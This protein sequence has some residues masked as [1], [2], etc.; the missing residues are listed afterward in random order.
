ML[1]QHIWI[2][3][4]A[5]FVLHAQGTTPREKPA[6]YHVQARLPGFDLAAEYLSHSMPEKGGV[7]DV[8]EYLVI[9]V[10]V[11]PATKEVAQIS[12]G[13]FMLQVTDTRRHKSVLLSQTPGMVAASLK[14]PNWELRPTLEASAGLGDGNVI[15]GRP[16]Q[17][18]RFPG[19]PRPRQ[20]R[21]PP[22]PKVPDQTNPTSD[23]KLPEVP[24]EVRVQQLAFP[25]GAVQGPV[26]G[27]LFFPFRGKTK[28]I[29]A[30]ELL[31]Q[32][33]DGSRK[34]TLALF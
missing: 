8:N 23:E 16:R 29:R 1:R 3:S 9:E 34:T 25:E 18:E 20:S 19:D 22:R 32:S 31:Y 12:G 33:P 13:E 24:I 5:I 17:T 27:Y 6:D 30:L 21:L 15:V 7:I 26:S 14:Y 28:S 4:L 10:A 11:F 2:A